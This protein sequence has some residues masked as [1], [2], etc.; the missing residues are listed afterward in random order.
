MGGVP[1][2]TVSKLLGHHDVKITENHYAHLSKDYM[3]N[4]LTEFQLKWQE[5]QLEK[6]TLISSK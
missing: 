3:G 6:T 4:V 1:I 2:Y 5:K